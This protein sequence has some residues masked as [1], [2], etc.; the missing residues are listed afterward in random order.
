MWGQ[1][2]I[3]IAEGFGVAVRNL[4]AAQAWYQEKLGMRKGPANAEDD[5]GL[6]FVALQFGKNRE[7]ISL[8]E[9][10]VE[11]VGGPLD[12]VRPMF[13]TKNLEKAHEWLLSRGVAAQPMQRDSGG[14]AFFTFRDL[15]GHTIEVCTES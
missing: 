14:N 15:E 13:F 3:Y 9:S 7:Y 4:S 6:P 1:P 10:D 5:S 11:I 8:V 12:I 2:P